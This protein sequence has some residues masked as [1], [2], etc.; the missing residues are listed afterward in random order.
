MKT[1]ARVSV[2]NTKP[3]MSTTPQM[4]PLNATVAVAPDGKSAEIWA[5]TQAPS[6]LISEVADALGIKADAVTFHQ[7]WVGGGWVEAAG[8]SR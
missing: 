1:A 4:E 2:A 5:G 8:A 6:N 3:A 7:Q